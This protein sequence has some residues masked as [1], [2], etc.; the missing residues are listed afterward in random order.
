MNIDGKAG[1]IAA[2]IIAL[3]FFMISFVTGVQTILAGKKM[4]FFQL[5]LT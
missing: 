4:K 2:T 1:V 3:I 5:R